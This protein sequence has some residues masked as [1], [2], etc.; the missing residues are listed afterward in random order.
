MGNKSPSYY[1]R[2]GREAFWSGVDYDGKNP[3][4]REGWEQA[5]KQQEKDQEKDTDY[6]GVCRLYSAENADDLKDWLEEYV[7]PMVFKD[8]GHP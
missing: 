4:I 1:R 5:R 7:L 6:L 8:R 3:D 2:M